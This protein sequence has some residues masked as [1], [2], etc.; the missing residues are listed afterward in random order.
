[1]LPSDL[2]DQLDR[3]DRK[4]TRQSRALN[5]VLIFNVILFVVLTFVF[6]LPLERIGCAFTALGWACVA[7][8]MR[9]HGVGHKPRTNALGVPSID[10]FRLNLERQRNFAAAWP[11]FLAAVPGPVMFFLGA[12]QQY[13]NMEKFLYVMLPAF[14]GLVVVV[15][16]QLVSRTRRF[17]TE[18]DE[19]T[20]FQREQA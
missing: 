4:A 2:R 16:T 3:R 12:A 13:P 15:I 18:I 7:F 5:A 10:S 1:M 9:R 6:P 19:L 20:E 17:Q 8:Q 14:L 11:W